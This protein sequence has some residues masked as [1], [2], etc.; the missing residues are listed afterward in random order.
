MPGETDQARLPWYSLIT[1]AIILGGFAWFT[2]YMVVSA[3]TIG[4]DDQ[5]HWDRLLLIFNAIQTLTVAAAGVLL[6]T[7]VQQARVASAENRA[8]AAQ[9]AATAA[10]TDAAKAAA[11]RKLIEQLD[12][13]GA[14]ATDRSALL[15]QVRAVLA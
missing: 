1:G 7:T 9:S 11:A 12:P 13:P 4:K 10:Q 6:G 2:Y 3:S 14:A 5:F 8:D 15:A